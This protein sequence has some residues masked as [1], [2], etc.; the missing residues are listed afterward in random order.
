MPRNPATSPATED[1]RARKFRNSVDS[2]ILRTIR[3]G[4]TTPMTSNPKP[5]SISL[6]EFCTSFP[7]L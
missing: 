4:R 2:S 7:Y 1:A 3:K 5:I 6:N